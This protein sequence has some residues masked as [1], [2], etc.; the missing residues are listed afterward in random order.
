MAETAEIQ[1]LVFE[2]VSVGLHTIKCMCCIFDI[3][4][5]ISKILHDVTTME[6]YVL[7]D[8]IKPVT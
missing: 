4:V 7:I 6:Y 5:S 1:V 3:L 2:Q 8:G